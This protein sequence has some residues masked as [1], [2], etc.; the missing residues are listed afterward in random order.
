[1]LH[2][3]KGPSTELRAKKDMKIGSNRLEI[4]GNSKYYVTISLFQ[5]SIFKH[6][7]D[8]IHYQSKFPLFVEKQPRAQKNK[9]RGITM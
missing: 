2:N 3:K 1:M 9:F 4:S 7:L 8:S 6:A 5:I